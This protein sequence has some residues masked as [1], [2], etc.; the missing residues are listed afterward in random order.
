MAAFPDG[1]HPDDMEEGVSEI[2]DDKN[3]IVY[4]EQDKKYPDVP[5]SIDMEEGD[6]KYDNA[7]I[8]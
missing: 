7:V 3:E 1:T 2:K 4:E 6:E 8:K 5:S